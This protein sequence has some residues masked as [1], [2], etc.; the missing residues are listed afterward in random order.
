M[1]HT[2]THVR[3]LT[4]AHAHIH[5]QTKQVPQSQSLLNFKS[6]AAKYSLSGL[7]SGTK[8]R[9]NAWPFE[10]QIRYRF[11]QNYPERNF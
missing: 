11:L 1:K 8:L 10:S 4:H 5:K 7:R 6:V 2:H 3:M 9:A